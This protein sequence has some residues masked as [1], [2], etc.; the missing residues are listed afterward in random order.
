MVKGVGTQ[1]SSTM[2]PASALPELNLKQLIRL[3]LTSNDD[4]HV[5]MTCVKAVTGME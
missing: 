5:V 4:A 2:S 3:C 1:K